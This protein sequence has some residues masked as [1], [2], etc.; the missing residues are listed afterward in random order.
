M[1]TILLNSVLRGEKGWMRVTALDPADGSAAA[2][3]E[4]PYIIFMS[5]VKT[6][7]QSQNTLVA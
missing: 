2:F 3:D 1:L 4:S 5:Q 7:Q 6:Q